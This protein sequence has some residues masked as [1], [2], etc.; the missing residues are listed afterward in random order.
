MNVANLCGHIADLQFHVI[1][2]EPQQTSPQPTT[3]IG[4]IQ[5]V[6]IHVGSFNRTNSKRTVTRSKSGEKRQAE[7]GFVGV[8]V[9]PAL[10]AGCEPLALDVLFAPVRQRER[11]FA[12][13]AGDTFKY[14]IS[15]VRHWVIPK[16]DYNT[17]MRVISKVTLIEFWRKHPAS[18]QAFQT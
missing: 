5:T 4:A 13:R 18:K 10:E 11:A 6:A 8:A 3:E 1:T 9:V 15:T 17:P 7:R 2:Q 14:S 12:I 16:W